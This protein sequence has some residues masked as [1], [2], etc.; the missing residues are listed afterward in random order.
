MLGIPAS[1]SLDE[2]KA[3]FRRRIKE[4]HPDVQG[5]LTDTSKVAELLIKAYNVAVERINSGKDASSGA[6]TGAGVFEEPTGPAHH[7]FVNDRYCRG[8]GCP[9][10]CCCVKTAPDAFEFSEETGR[11]SLRSGGLG[12]RLGLGEDED[13]KLWLAVGQ[14]PQDCLH[15]VSKDQ[16]EWLLD[17]RGSFLYDPV[18][19]Q[20]E[21]DTLLATAKFE[22][23]RWN[24][25]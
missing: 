5:S 17:L 2:V 16:Q 9:E 6:T 13:Y 23:G 4:I 22:N 24:G 18:M 25:K 15:F 1:S 8:T 7:V 10:W 3:Q 11:A 21:I 12:S 14:C 20:S 19:A